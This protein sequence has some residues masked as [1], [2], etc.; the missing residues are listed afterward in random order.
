MCLGEIFSNLVGEFPRALKASFCS[1][2]AQHG[3]GHALAIERP[4]EPDEVDLAD[5]WP[6]PEGG[7]DP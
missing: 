6:G 7:A 2:S 1:K 3:K 4:V 5:E